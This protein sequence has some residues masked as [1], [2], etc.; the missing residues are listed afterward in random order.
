MYGS[1]FIRSV[2]VHFKTDGQL[3]PTQIFPKNPLEN[4]PRIKKFK[5]TLQKSI[6]WVTFG[7]FPSFSLCFSSLSLYFLNRTNIFCHLSVHNET[8]STSRPTPRG[9]SWRPWRPL[10]YIHENDDVQTVAW[11]GT[12]GMGGRHRMDGRDGACNGWDR[13]DGRDGTRYGRWHWVKQM[14]G[15]GPGMDGIGG[16]KGPP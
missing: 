1:I 14:E 15:M 12:D 10:P 2:K 11:G 9:V 7:I 3:R 13:I 16:M 4:T 8:D 6:N 5:L